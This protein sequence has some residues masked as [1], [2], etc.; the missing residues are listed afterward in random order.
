MQQILAV[1]ESVRI[2]LDGQFITFAR[3][4][5]Q[6]VQDTDLAEAEQVL[7]LLAQKVAGNC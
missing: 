1:G 7:N 5:L 4:D 2:I 3:V 6:P